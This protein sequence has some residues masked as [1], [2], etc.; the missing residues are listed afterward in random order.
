M[1]A[2]GPAPVTRRLRRACAADAGVTLVEVLVAFGV[3]SVVMAVFT[4]GVAQSYRVANKADAMA[5]ARQQL[6]TAFLRLDRDVRYAFAIRSPGVVGD[7]S[8]VEY[9]VNNTGPVRCTQLRID[10]TNRVLQTRAMDA[11]GVTSRWSTLA[12]HVASGG[13]TRRAPAGAAH[14]ELVVVLT[15]DVGRGATRTQAPAEYSFA[16]LNTTVDV[17]DDSICS[18]MSRA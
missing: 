17:V 3:M 4:A 1:F 7:R 12:S 14:Q 10:A 9:A 11:G 18:G 16:A 6:H 5:V 15:P 2:D 8:Y 13:F